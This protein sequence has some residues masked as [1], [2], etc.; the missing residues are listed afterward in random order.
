MKKTFWDSQDTNLLGGFFL[1]S[2]D[3]QKT[4]T[5]K[6]SFSINEQKRGLAYFKFYYSCFP[7]FDNIFSDCIDLRKA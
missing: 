7:T 4:F 2:F 1:A 3:H 6:R 5:D